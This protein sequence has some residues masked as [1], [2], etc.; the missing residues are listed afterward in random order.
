MMT[1]TPTKARG[2]TPFPDATRFAGAVRW[3]RDDADLTQA[4]L[5]QRVG[6]SAEA[7]SKIERLQNGHLRLGTALRIARYFQD[8]TGTTLEQMTRPDP[9]GRW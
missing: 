1:D 5:A 6:L 8:R 9:D 7:I 3:L 4:E 2:R